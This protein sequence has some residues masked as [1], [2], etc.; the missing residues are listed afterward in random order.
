V[1]AA[2]VDVGEG[3]EGQNCAEANFDSF[4]GEL[5]GFHLASNWSW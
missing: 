4:G 2:A 5:V 3:S 1:R